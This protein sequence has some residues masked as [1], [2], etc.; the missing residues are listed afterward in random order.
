[1]P[2]IGRFI[3]LIMTL[4]TIHGALA[5]PTANPAD[6]PFTIASLSGPVDTILSSIVNC[7]T[8]TCQI[9]YSVTYSLPDADFKL[10]WKDVHGG[11]LLATDGLCPQTACD[12]SWDYFGVQPFAQPSYQQRTGIADFTGSHVVQQPCVGYICGADYHEFTDRSWGPV[13]DASE[14]NLQ[15]ATTS[16]VV[17]REVQEELGDPPVSTEVPVVELA[18]H[19]DIQGSE[20]HYVYTIS[21]LT[22][23]PLV[24]VL[25]L[26][27]WS[28]VVAP[29]NAIEHS[30][31]ALHG[32]ARLGRT[33]ASLTFA[34]GRTLSGPFEFLQPV[35]VPASLY[36]MLGG[37]A[38]VARQRLKRAA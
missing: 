33:T 6:T 24:F 37:M 16:S 35:P 31:L 3:A 8:P 18:N 19:V 7:G 10:V 12:F 1:M 32:A 4:S 23:D 26:L 25:P 11:T 2:S 20:F 34:S 5:A 27:G 15:Q 36:M 38:V 29:H 17:V 30:L 14:F 28:G 22:D 21:N 9:T 13:G